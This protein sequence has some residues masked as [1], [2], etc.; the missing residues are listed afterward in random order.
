M[1]D[2][3]IRVLR[4]E[5]AAIHREVCASCPSIA[6]ERQL[7]ERETEIVRELRSLGVGPYPDRTRS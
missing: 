7:Q 5:Y 4:S 1:V 2:D 3:L 6:R